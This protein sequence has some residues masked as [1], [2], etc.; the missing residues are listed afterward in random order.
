MKICTKC[1]EI[2][3]HTDFIKNNLTKD[4]YTYQCKDCRNKWFREYNKSRRGIDYKR[5]KEWRIKNPDKEKKNAIKNRRIQCIKQ[6]NLTEQWY[7]ETLGKQNNVCAI[8]GKPETAKNKS[9]SLDHCHKT[10][11]IRGF[12]CHNCN[13][14]LGKFKDNQGLLLNAFQYLYRAEKEEENVSN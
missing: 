12:L 4:G 14:G 8:C 11:K 9:L 5:L 2:K 6:F 10:N 3:P 13:T 1:K 7:Y